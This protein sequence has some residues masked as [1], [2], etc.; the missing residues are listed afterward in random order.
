MTTCKFCHLPLTAALSGQLGGGPI[1]RLNSKTGNVMGPDFIARACYDY[2][3]VSPAPGI[4]SRRGD[5]RFM[6]YSTSRSNAAAS[7]VMSELRYAAA[8]SRMI[9]AIGSS[10]AMPVVVWISARPVVGWRSAFAIR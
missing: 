6:R 8:R 9:A 3:I 2:S 7:N 5:S 10:D 4:F 1:C